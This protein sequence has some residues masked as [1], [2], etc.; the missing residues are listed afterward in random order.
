MLSMIQADPTPRIEELKHYKTEELFYR[1]NGAVPILLVWK[2][3]DGREL[4]VKEQRGIA[5]F[6]GVAGAHIKRSF[7]TWEAATKFGRQYGIE[8]RKE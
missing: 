7:D 3:T 8:E 2:R 6:G 5:K 4:T 1:W